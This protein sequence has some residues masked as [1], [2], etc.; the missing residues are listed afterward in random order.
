MSISKLSVFAPA[1]VN[2]HLAVL[3]RRED[4]FHN[5]ES[6]FLA[7]D[8]GDTLHFE[9]IEGKNAFEI[10]MEGQNSAIPPEKNIIFNALSLFRE[11]TAFSQGI[12]I[13]VEKRIPLG[14]G[15]GGGSSNAA[16]TL[17]ALNKLTGAPL[18]RNT[19]L[20]MAAALG[21]D[22]PFFVSEIP[23]AWVTGRG[24]HITPVE[25]PRVSLVLV[26]PGF[27]SNTAEAFRLLA[28]A[29]SRKNCTRHW[30]RKFNHGGHRVTQIE[31]LEL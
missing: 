8:F 10:S 13:H 16:V 21:S 6:L 30:K 27:S 5:L 3:D 22:V 1:K 20:D 25:A 24:E 11:K 19:L 4:G 18:A 7:V 2:L 29:R 12:N 23:A 9:P 17:L 28:E 31:N 14:G 15:L 26:N